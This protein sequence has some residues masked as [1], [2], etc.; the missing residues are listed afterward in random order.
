MGLTRPGRGRGRGHLRHHDV[1]R[2]HIAVALSATQGR[3]LQPNEFP[4]PVPSA[5]SA[6]SGS[7]TCDE[8]EAEPDAERGVAL[9]G[10]GVVPC[11]AL[12]VAA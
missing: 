11:R 9:L 3:T 7:L 12:N 1:A 2:M 6:V 10:L 5:L 8:Y 4:S